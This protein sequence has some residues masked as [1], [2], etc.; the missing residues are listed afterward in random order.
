M[1]ED[2]KLETP[3]FSSK[4]I[5]EE[6][7]TSLAGK[8]KTHCPSVFNS[9][10]LWERDLLSKHLGSIKT[11][12]EVFDR[13]RLPALTTTDP[14]ELGKKSHSE[15]SSEASPPTTLPFPPFQSDV[16]HSSPLAR[17]IDRPPD[18]LSNG[19]DLLPP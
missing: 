4:D 19:N 17:E 12:G 15:S 11:F 9:L 5:S 1:D 7:D 14:V 2:G 18:C 10:S 16:S 3:P 13:G 8:L 6:L